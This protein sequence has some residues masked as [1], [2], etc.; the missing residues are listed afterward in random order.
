MRGL[1]NSWAPISVF[2]CPPAVLKRYL[3]AVTVV[4]P[5]FDVDPDSS[6]DEFAREAR[7]HPVLRLTPPAAQ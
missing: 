2:V 7:R 3:K 5:F 6:L 4:R 1:R